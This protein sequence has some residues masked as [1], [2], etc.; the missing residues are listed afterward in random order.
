MPDCLALGSTY[1]VF[2]DLPCSLITLLIFPRL[3]KTFKKV[4]YSE[5]RLPTIH[6]VQI[7]SVCDYKE[8]YICFERSQTE[9]TS[10]K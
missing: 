10:D 9:A 5:E 8:T 7:R 6:N 1:K 2:L 3:L 4:Q